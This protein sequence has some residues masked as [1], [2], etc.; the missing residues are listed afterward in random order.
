MT[1]VQVLHAVVAHLI[2]ITYT[3]HSLI[4]GTKRKEELHLHR[5]LCRHCSM[6]VGVPTETLFLYHEVS[7]SAKPQRAAPQL[8]ARRI[9]VL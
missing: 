9:R 4:E 6:R 1:A 5:D 2:Y 7:S 8:D 3:L